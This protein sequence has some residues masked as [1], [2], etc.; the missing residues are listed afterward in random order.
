MRARFI[1]HLPSPPQTVILSDN[2]SRGKARKNQKQIYPPA[3]FSLAK[4]GLDQFFCNSFHVIS[5]YSSSSFQEDS[6]PEGLQVIQ[7]LI[8]L[9]EEVS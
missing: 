8:R 5:W 3:T 1:T 6:L 4:E 2:V 7:H 9:A